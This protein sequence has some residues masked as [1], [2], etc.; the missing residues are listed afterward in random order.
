[1]KFLA[2]DIGCIECGE[3]SEVLGLFDTEVEAVDKCDEMEKLGWRGGQHSY[4]VFK[5]EGL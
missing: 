4:E 3:S 1:V 2:M 5:L